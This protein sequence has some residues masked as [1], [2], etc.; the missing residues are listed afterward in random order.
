MYLFRS[1]S[2]ITLILFCAASLF[3]LSFAINSEAATQTAVIVTAESSFTGSGALSVVAVDPVGGPRTTANLVN[4]Y[5]HNDLTVF[6]HGQYFYVIGRSSMDNI[7]KYA[8]QAP[9]KIIWQYST[10]TPSEQNSNPQQL[11]FL[12]DTKAYLTRLGSAK[13]WIVDPSATTEDGF[14]QSGPGGY[15]DLSNYA[16]E[17]I[18][19]GLPKDHSGVIVDVNNNKYLFISLEEID[20]STSP[21][22]Y[23]TPKI[24]VIDTATDQVV[25]TI[26]IPEVKN[27][28]EMQYLSTTNT[29]YVQCIGDWTPGTQTM[30]GIVAINPADAVDAIHNNLSYTPQVVIRGDA[31][32]YGAI[33]GMAIVSADKGY[34]VGYAGWGDNSLYSFDPSTGKV[35]QKI[36]EKDLQNTN[37]YGFENG[38]SLDQNGMLWICNLS[39]MEVDILN[40]VTDKIDERIPTSQGPQKVAFADG[41]P[42]DISAFN[43]KG[44]SGGGGGCFISTLGR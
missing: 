30:S 41:A 16:D 13:V 10:D 9:D 28:Y 31:S 23:Y 3:L 42:T 22:Q 43:N 14:H 4:V 21:I 29:L 11:I 18:T 2:I 37:L 36:P 26:S 12:N 38:I 32:D 6:A 19:D 24:V 35:L 27:P 7:T 17:G 5:Q 39:K 44:S 15:I 25:G 1:K 8:I 20:F 40:P 34:F 33:S